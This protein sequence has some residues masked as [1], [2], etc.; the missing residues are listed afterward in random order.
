MIEAT[1]LVPAAG[2]GRRLGKEAN[3]AFVSVAGK[4]IL[5]HTLAV[6]ETC[7]AVRDVVLVV[8]ERE[9][10]AAGE[11]VDRFGFAKVSAVVAG[12]GE[13]QD[14]VRSGL[15]HV[16]S[17]VVAIHDA[18]RPFVTSDIIVRS[19]ERALEM[20]ACIAAVPVIDTIKRAR[21]DG[22]V[23]KTIDRG[24]LFAVQTPQTF[25]T[26]LIRLAH[27]RAHTEGVY[28]TDDAAL[29]ERLGEK[30]S[31]VDGSYE[32]VK[33]T[34]PAD[35]EA[36]QR[37]L[38]VGST[39]TGIGF[40]AHRLVEGRRLVLGGVEIEY[41]K[42]LLGHSDADVMLHALSDALLG[43]AALGDIGKHFPDSDAA[44]KDASSLNLLSQVGDLL[45]AR[46]W[47]IVCV[48]T[49]LA[50]ERPKIA[51]YVDEMAGNISHALGIP[52]DAVSIKATTTEGMGYIGRGEG[53][54]CYAVANIECGGLG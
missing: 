49:V 8:G 11:L 13:R 4:P 21:P 24:A 14:S 41:E 5:A 1:A 33:I 38:G 35:L 15:E 7:K 6:F 46:G 23:G 45:R 43:A 44:Y 47:R 40:D 20:G 48:D 19:I 28:A 51:R 42:G 18:A 2:R 26:E 54:S 9:I 39:R 17:S 31:I 36:A 16:R 30:V 34:T 22:C 29:V 52:P 50:C 10:E 32:N 37:R 3:K 27:G 53:I 12:G 25:R